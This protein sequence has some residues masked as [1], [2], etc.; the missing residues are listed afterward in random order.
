MV[1]QRQGHRFIKIQYN[2]LGQPICKIPPCKNIAEK[3]K[4]GSY[5]T[6]CK[7]HSCHDL[8]DYTSWQHV[9]V[10][11]LKRD[12]YTCVKCGDNREYTRRE[13][14]CEAIDENKEGKLIIVNKIRG[15]TY[16]NLIADHIKPIALG[17]DE[18]D[19]E[20]IQTLCYKCNKIKTA[21]DIKDI[22]KLRRLEKL[23]SKGQTFIETLK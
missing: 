16:P 5:R 22:A 14:V 7:K 4:N 2:K 17:G 20:N 18:W 8:W 11:A 9:R 1:K 15:Y 6:Y 21:Q 23:Q 13:R 19:L 3:F 10:R 12:N